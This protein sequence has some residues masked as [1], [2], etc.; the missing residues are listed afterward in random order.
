MYNCI[1]KYQDGVS[2][3]TDTPNFK[4]ITYHKVSN[5]I[6]FT[7]FIDRKF[8]DWKYFNVFDAKTRQPVASFTINDRP[9]K[10]RI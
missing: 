4:F 5:L 10:P 3:F 1:V 8:P 9:L 7:G 2:Y 6:K